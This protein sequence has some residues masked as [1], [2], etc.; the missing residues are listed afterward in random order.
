[1]RLHPFR[2]LHPAAGLAAQ[3]ASPPYDVMSRDEARAMAGDN[4]RSFL[5]VIR[6]EI[7]LADEVDPHG[8]AV[9]KAGRANL[10]R[11]RAEGTL[12][13][14]PAPALWLYRL[15]MGDHVQT[16]FVGA[17]EVADY[18]ADRIKKHEFT[19]PD[20]EDDRT[21]HTDLLGANTGPVFLAC[22]SASALEA[23]QEEVARG[24]PDVDFTAPDGIQHTLWRIGDP[25]LLQRAAAAF[26]GIDAFYIADGHHRAKSAERVRDLRH[27]RQP[28]AAAPWHRFLTVVFPDTQLKVLPY[29]RVVAD[30]NGHSAPAF[31]EALAADFEI[32]PPGASAEPP[33]RH[34]FGM[35]LYNE[36]GGTWRRLTARPHV[37][38][39]SDP[40][41]CLDVAILQDRVLGPLLGIEDP[42]TSPRVSFVGGIRGTAELERR[43]DAAGEGLAVAMYPTSLAELFAVADAGRVMPP[44][45]T[46]FEPKLRSGLLVHLLD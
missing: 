35:Y 38:D 43:V 18:T 16:G 31:L 3:V 14:D 21:R 37:V 19:R 33:E 39:E 44:K 25:A 1:M 4:A 2:A 20:K 45:S 13:Q 40:V 15:R 17:S 42:R 29:N 32:G 24:A 6:P 7:G 8:E 11:L 36:G 23:L 28:D 46:W 34:Q 5:H 10:E 27:A 26:E 22:R 41:A 12:V 30:L 9:Y